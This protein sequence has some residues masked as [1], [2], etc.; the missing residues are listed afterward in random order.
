MTSNA[1]PLLGLVAD[2]LAQ[3][4]YDKAAREVKKQAEKKGVALESAQDESETAPTLGELYAQWQ[5]Q[6]PAVAKAGDDSNDSSSSSDDDDS[7]SS[8][9]EEEEKQPSKK[10]KASPTPSSSSASSTSESESDEDVAPPPKKAKKETKKARAASPSSSSASSSASSESDDSDDDSG[11]ASSSSDDDDEDGRSSS[12]SSGS[13]ESD[14]SSSSSSSS[15][16]DSDS[17]SSSSE[18]DSDSDSSSSSSS[19]EEEKSKKSKKKSK[20]TKTVKVTIKP[21]TD[22]SRSSSA[23]LTGDSANKP[24]DTLLVPAL[25]VAGASASTSS[26]EH[27]GMHPDRLA[28]M[29]NTQ[30]RTLKRKASNTFETPAA[31]PATDEN[32]KRLKKAN[33]PF[34]RIPTDQYVDP[35]FSDNRFVHY[36]YAQKAHEAL[37]VTK[38][39]GFTKAKN[40]GKRGSYKGG[41]IDLGVGAGTIKFED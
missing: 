30:S 5:A 23:T 41:K 17:D 25:P 7:G 8:E 37:I 32:I 18:S 1:Q 24:T 4:G 39:K 33:V 19:S 13:E 27:S 3:N 28:G 2:F 11:S 20:D 16:S 31:V 36:D 34:S 21:E 35:K 29:Q 26:D 12:S 9:D 6:Q 10:R 40:K 38:G 14:S 22:N 15:S